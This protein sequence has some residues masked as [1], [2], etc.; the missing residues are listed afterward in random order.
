[1]SKITA[2][3]R[4]TFVITA[5]QELGI[6]DLDSEDVASA[7]ELEFSRDR[8]AVAS[9]SEKLREAGE[10]LAEAASVLYGSAFVECG[11]MELHNGAGKS[12]TLED[13]F[14]EEWEALNDALNEWC[15]VNPQAADQSAT[16]T[17]EA[18]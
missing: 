7:I 5:L 11:L 3:D 10:K 16:P 4:A 14:K 13:A 15:E 9:E 12:K 1:M 2:R 8:K 17:Q 6:F 18:S